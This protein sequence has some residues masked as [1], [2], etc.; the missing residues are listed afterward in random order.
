M[1]CRVLGPYWR[2]WPPIDPADWRIAWYTGLRSLAA[3][4][5]AG[6]RAAFDAVYD[7]LPGELA[8]KL[9]LAFA[10]EAA[11]DPAAAGRYFQL[12]WTVDRAYVSAAFGLARTRLRA[13]DRAGAIA[14]LAAVPD[15]SSHHLAAQ[16]A[17]VRIQV[18]PR[19][20]QA[21]VS[22]GDLGEA[23]AR[24]D[25]LKLDAIQMEYL[26]AEV[27][28]AALACVVGQR[29][30]CPA[31]RTAAW[32]RVHRARVAVRPGAQLPGP[33]PA[34][35]GP[36]PPDRAGRGGQQHPPED[37][38]MTAGPLPSEDGPNSK[39]PSVA[40]PGSPAQAGGRACPS[41][42]RAVAATDNFCEGCRTELAP[43][44][45]SGDAPVTASECAFC[46]AAQLTADGYCESCGRK[47]PAVRDHT[48][49]DLGMLAGVTDRGLR[50]HRNEDAM[51]LATAELASGPAAVAVV[52][53]G[54]SSTR[55]P[56]EASLAAAQAAVQV[57]LT[58]VR[59]RRGPARPLPCRGRRG[60]AVA[61]RPG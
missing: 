25:R 58:G 20:G 41:C 2:T 26:T 31:R 52:C 12:V 24:V 3:D 55:R 29:S 46:H 42:G 53:D 47:Q 1:T 36:A 15:S 34:G 9:A 13:G 32:L 56:D 43:A 48:E 4:N 8:A 49:L 30:R 6:A 59:D 39:V 44:A 11:G 7:A 5:P 45:V 57:L 18:S 35:T 33:G 51:A 38:G 28:R 50:H 22:P 17:A 14:A 27:L 40:A 19:P 54:V 23:G 61:G 16:I 37:L 60:A 10:A 21:Q